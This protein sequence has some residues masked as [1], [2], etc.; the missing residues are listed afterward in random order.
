M[1]CKNGEE[2]NSVGRPRK[3]LNLDDWKAWLKNDWKHLNWKVNFMFAV[4][5]ATFGAAIAR[6]FIG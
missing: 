5:L 2:K 6:L 4:L 3:Y 1:S